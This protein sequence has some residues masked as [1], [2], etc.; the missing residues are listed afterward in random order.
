MSAFFIVV[1]TIP[2]DASG[3]KQERGSYD[4]YVDRVK[5]IVERFGGKYVIRSEKVA[6]FAGEE[7]PDRIIVIEFPG[8]DELRRCF[9]SPEYKAVAGLRTSSVKTS[10]FIVES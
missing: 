6:V 4:E 7:R 10:A 1:I 5:P 2:K 9:D 3:E 8:M